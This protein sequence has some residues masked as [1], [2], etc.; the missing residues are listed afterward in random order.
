MLTATHRPLTIR[1]QQLLR[2]LWTTVQKTG[3]YPRV[4]QMMEYL[5]VA[6]PNGAHCTLRALEA[7]GFVELSGSH[8]D[9]C[10][11]IG[12]RLVPQIEDS[13]A[14]QRLWEELER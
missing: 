9:R 2:F 6:S 11:L 10:S 12:V 8:G 1:Q 13:P 4:R 7:K 3:A 14:G 5:K